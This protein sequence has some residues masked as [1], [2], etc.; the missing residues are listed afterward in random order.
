MILTTSTPRPTATLSAAGGMFGGTKEPFPGTAPEEQVVV[1]GQYVRGGRYDL[2]AEVEEKYQGKKPQILSLACAA[3]MGIAGG[4]T[5]ANVASQIAGLPGLEGKLIG[6]GVAA[7]A[8]FA[9]YAASDLASGVFHHWIDNYPKPSDPFIGRLAAEFQG[10]HRDHYSLLHS[11]FLD[12][13]ARAGVFLAPLMVATAVVNPHYALGTAALT[14][15]GGGFLAQGSHRWAHQEN[16]P[17]IGKFCQKVGLAQP[18]QNHAEHH[19]MP[20]ATNYCIVNGMWNPLMEKYDGWRKLEWLYHKISGAVPETWN[21]EATRKLALGEITKEEFL[22]LHPYT[23]KDFAAMA[24]E[25]W[26]KD[27]VQRLGGWKD[28]EEPPASKN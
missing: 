19:D 23:V 27:F 20:W 26:D 16:P 25:R 9:G 17:A 28:S 3:T 6:I 13:C 14:F 22:K 12:N 7:A 21:D 11:T 24:Q 5:A 10:H 2:S 15:L 1:D 4:W 18:K 8:A